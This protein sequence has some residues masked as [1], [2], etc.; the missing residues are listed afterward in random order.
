MRKK[1]LKLN[2]IEKP[3]IAS[4]DTLTRE[5][6]RLRDDLT[7]QRCGKKK[8]HGWKME[9]AHHYSRAM[10]S[11]RWDLDNVVLLC[12]NCHYLWGHQ[13][14]NE[15]SEWWKQRLGETKYQM[16]QLRKSGGKPDLWLTKMYLQQEI[17]KIEE[18]KEC[19]AGEKTSLTNRGIGKL[20]S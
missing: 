13:N 10:K 20:S 2:I 1:S 3:S 8:I 7:C 6:V 5:A 12:F 9:V 19:N 17:K 11:V 14:P 16:L 15:F 18:E 4:L